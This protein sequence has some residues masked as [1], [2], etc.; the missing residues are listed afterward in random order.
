MRKLENTLDLRHR[1]G[2]LPSEMIALLKDYPKDAWSNNINLGPVTLFWLRKHKMFRDLGADL[3][4]T[5]AQSAA[6]KVDLYRNL[7]PVQHKFQKFFGEL[8]LHHHVEDDHYFPIYL[9][10]A[11]EMSKGLDLLENDHN[12]LHVELERTIKATRKMFAV[13]QKPVQTRHDATSELADAFSS[14]NR[15]LKR[16]L[17][18]EEDII[19]PL[20]LSRGER[21][22]GI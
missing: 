3:N 11:P 19:V 2:D 16:H 5:L 6:G 20:V 1:Q 12:F 22:L 14:L 15:F 4:R 9:G 10:A 8:H 7:T 21:V 18:D 17:N 13:T